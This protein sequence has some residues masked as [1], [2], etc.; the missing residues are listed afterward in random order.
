MTAEEL[1]SAVKFEAEKY[2]P[3]PVNEVYLDAKIIKESYKE[4]KMLVLLA[5]AKK[6]L[7][8]GRIN[9]LNSVGLEPAIINV[10]VLA[11]INAFNFFEPSKATLKKDEKPQPVALLNVE[12]NIANLS[13]LE[14][15]LPVFS[16]D[17]ILGQREASLAT[18]D[19]S[20]INLAN[21]IRLSFDFYESQENVPISN[22]FMSGSLQKTKGVDTFLNQNL[23]VEIKTWDPFSKLSFI[24]NLDKAILK[25]RESEFTVAIGSALR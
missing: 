22:L 16:R 7:V 3:Y 11:V 21:E 20:L 14:A 13:I 6:D 18:S 19:S 15:S 10:S 9:L 8:Q 17:I 2:I 1:N 5:A 4:N 12:E 24:P 25:D 23:G